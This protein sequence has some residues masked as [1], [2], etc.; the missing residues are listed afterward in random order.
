M[1]SKTLSLTMRP[2]GNI[3]P[4]TWK[5][6]PLFFFLTNSSTDAP[7][8]DRDEIQVRLIYDAPAYGRHSFAWLYGKTAYPLT[9]A[10]FSD[11]EDEL[12]T[13]DDS[14][15][16]GPWGCPSLTTDSSSSSE[17][18]CSSEID[19]D[20]SSYYTDDSGSEWDIEEYYTEWDGPEVV[21]VSWE[22]WEQL[23]E[24]RGG[25]MRGL[26]P[27]SELWGHGVLNVDEDGFP[28]FEEFDF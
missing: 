12:D 2:C 15:S 26:F 19:S 22:Q 13:T 6:T 7:E 18:G 14:D 25:G 8:L 23:R 9:A 4:T 20:W 3:S 21:E 11:D 16:D 27:V 10:T 1:Q 28:A 24:L 5:G 17:S